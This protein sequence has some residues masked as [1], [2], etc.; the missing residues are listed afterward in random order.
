MP[1]PSGKVEVCH[2][3]QRAAR[4]WTGG[5]RDACTHALSEEQGSNTRERSGLSGRV[6]F[7]TQHTR[8]WCE[9][10]SHSITCLSWPQLICVTLGEQEKDIVIGVAMGEHWENPQTISMTPADWA[11]RLHNLQGTGKNMRENFK[12]VSYLHH[13]ELLVVSIPGDELAVF[14]PSR[15][16][17]ATAQHAEGKDTPLVCSLDGMADA[18][19]ACRGL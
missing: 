2:R 19:S 7:S 11:K 18:V 14:A 8:G 10:E 1:L 5:D 4:T 16:Q 6:T 12:L 9:E 17:C 3:S 13:L 15:H